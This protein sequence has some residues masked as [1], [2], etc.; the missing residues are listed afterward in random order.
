VPGNGREPGTGIQIS[1]ELLLREV[2][3][4]KSLKSKKSRPKILGTVRNRLHAA[5]QVESLDSGAISTGPDQYPKFPPS[6]KPRFKDVK[7]TDEQN[8]WKKQIL[9]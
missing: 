8:L 4:W 9:L 6:L 7:S 1:G 5:W 3:K 2:E